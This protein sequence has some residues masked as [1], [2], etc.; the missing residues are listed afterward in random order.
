MPSVYYQQASEWSNPR[1]EVEKTMLPQTRAN[2]E[3]RY[4]FRSEMRQ[5]VEC[6]RKNLVEAGKDIAQIEKSLNFIVM[7]QEEAKAVRK[8]AQT[9]DEVET[10]TGSAL[11]AAVNPHVTPTSPRKEK[12]KDAEKKKEHH[13]LKGTSSST[14]K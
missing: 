7:L 9:E 11:R 10:P 2:L 14:P 5:C 3:F 1:I 12:R 6:D 8:K 4:L 13:P